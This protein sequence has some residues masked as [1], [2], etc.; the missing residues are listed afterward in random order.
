V[1]CTHR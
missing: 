1:Y